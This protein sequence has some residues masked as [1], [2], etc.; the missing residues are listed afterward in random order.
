MHALSQQKIHIYVKFR[1]KKPYFTRFFCVFTDGGVR[2][3]LDGFAMR[4]LY[5]HANFP[6]NMRKIHWNFAVLNAY[7]A[8]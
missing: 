6:F 2:K 8:V 3:T 7:A 4:R 5:I 1:Y